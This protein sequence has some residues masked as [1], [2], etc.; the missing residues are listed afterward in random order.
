MITGSAIF[1]VHAGYELSIERKPP[2]SFPTLLFRPLGVYVG[3]WAVCWE[4]QW[5]YRDDH[6]DEP[7]SGRKWSILGGDIVNR[8][9]KE[10]VR[11]TSARV[12]DYQGTVLP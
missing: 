4:V 1:S 7:Y 11:P 9:L 2:N 12:I 10:Y 3:A 5:S 6:A 8:I